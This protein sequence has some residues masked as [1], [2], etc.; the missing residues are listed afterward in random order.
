[1][2]EGTPTNV[3]DSG[4][5]SA[6]AREQN[7]GAVGLEHKGDIE[8]AGQPVIGILSRETG[9]GSEERSVPEPA[10]PTDDETAPEAQAT[11]VEPMDGIEVVQSGV[12]QNGNGVVTDEVANV[13]SNH[14]HTR[15]KA[16]PQPDD[17][18]RP[19]PAYKVMNR[20]GY[21]PDKC[22]VCQ[23]NVGKYKCPRCQLK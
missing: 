22:I 11:N 8:S 10:N 17:Q 23:E 13:R 18:F 2:S 9:P 19:E 16:E 3:E 1:M 21:D 4:S 15:T 20:R 12:K 7:E 14:H 5:V 6:A